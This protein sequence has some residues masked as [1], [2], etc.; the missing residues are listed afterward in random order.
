M[1]ARGISILFALAVALVFV[2][3]SI[4]GAVAKTKVAPYP[5]H[6]WGTGMVY[7][8]VDHYVVMFSGSNG[9]NDTWTFAA[10]KWT[11]L[12]QSTAPTN[13]TYPCMV[14]DAKDGYI[15]LFGGHQGGKTTGR[16]MNDTWEF[17]D[18][19]WTQLHPAVSP[20]PLYLSGCAYDA[21]AGYV[22]LF[23]G[24][25]A[26]PG[27]DSTNQTWSY[28][29][30]VWTQLHP[31]AWPLTRYGEVMFYDAAM[32]EIVL[33]GGWTDDKSVAQ[34]DG[35]CIPS[36][37]PYL[38]DTWIYAGGDWK[39]ELAGPSPPGHVYDSV[40]YDGTSGYWVIFGGQQSASKTPKSTQNATWAYEGSAWVNL[41]VTHAP[42][43]EFGAGMTYDAEDGYDVLFGGLSGTMVNAPLNNYTWTYASGVWTNITATS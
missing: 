20:P 9:K 6:R 19:K 11:K 42:G 2:G 41:T 10:G 31:K 32:S 15:L 4:G 18:G 12:T 26:G 29:G 38:N 8:P 39:R 13:R 25:G 43:T 14:W 33:Y 37:C 30:G 40:A 3:A 21:T 23:G 34:A 36:L 22:L 24:H 16:L 7:D 1:G 35:L 27:N 17:L 28:S 5:I